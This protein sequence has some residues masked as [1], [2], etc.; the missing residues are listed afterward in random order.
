MPGEKPYPGCY[1]PG[2]GPPPNQEESD[3]LWELPPSGAR[4]TN[5]TDL[6][7]CKPTYCRGIAETTLQDTP[8]RPDRL[9][10]TGIQLTL[11]GPDSGMDR[12]QW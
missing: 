3:L 8:T 7:T 2:G 6:L 9:R 10:G 4:W 11:P 1:G 5:V 12:D